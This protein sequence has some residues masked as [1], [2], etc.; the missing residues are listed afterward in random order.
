MDVEY[1][2]EK[3]ED[4]KSLNYCFLKLKE[5]KTNATVI[6]EQKA[7]DAGQYAVRAAIREILQEDKLFPIIA[8]GESYPLEDFNWF[9]ETDTPAYIAKIE[10]YISEND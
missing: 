3:V 9:V 6:N 1:F 4:L 5:W 10:K 2:K 7:A 8:L